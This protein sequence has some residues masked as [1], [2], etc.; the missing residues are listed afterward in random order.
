M[1]DLSIKIRFVL[2]TRQHIFSFNTYCRSD[3]AAEAPNSLLFATDVINQS[4][5]NS[6]QKAKK[7]YGA[8]NGCLII[9][10]NTEMTL[11]E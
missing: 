5:I 8:L 4:I 1:Q 6:I 10:G 11:F 2:A 7:L 3:K 9:G